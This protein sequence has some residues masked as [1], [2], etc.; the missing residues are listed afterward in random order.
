MIGTDLESLV[1]R[2]P[3]NKDTIVSSG[4]S[5]FIRRQDPDNV[6]FQV[7]ENGYR[8]EVKTDEDNVKEAAE[9]WRDEVIPKLR[10]DDE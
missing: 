7:Y 9:F 10:G 5:F 8:I 1:N 6:D 2:L 3:V 4:I